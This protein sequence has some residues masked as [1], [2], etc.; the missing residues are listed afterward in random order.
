[1]LNC[2]EFI[3]LILDLVFLIVIVGELWVLR[4]ALDWWLSFDYV[5][6][7]YKWLNKHSKS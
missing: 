2:S 3:I 1:M 6:E 5:K 4:V 7:F